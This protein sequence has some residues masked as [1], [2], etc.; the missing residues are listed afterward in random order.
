[1]ENFKIGDTVSGENTYGYVIAIT[2]LRERGFDHKYLVLKCP[3]TPCD[4]IK[5]VVPAWVHKV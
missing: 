1:M 3:G 5:I 4:T 2:T